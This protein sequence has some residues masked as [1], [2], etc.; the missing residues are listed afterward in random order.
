[1]LHIRAVF[2]RVARPTQDIGYV[3]LGVY[4]MYGLPD[5]VVNIYVGPKCG[6]GESQKVI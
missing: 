6:G 4:S 5:T 1:M 3:G 2:H